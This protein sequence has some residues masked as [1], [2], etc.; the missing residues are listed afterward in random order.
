M[1]CFCGPAACLGVGLL[2]GW[3]E[4]CRARGV[5]ALR[6]KLAW[7]FCLDGLSARLGHVFH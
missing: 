3:G 4:V 7:L 1:P 6:G 2:G 5:S